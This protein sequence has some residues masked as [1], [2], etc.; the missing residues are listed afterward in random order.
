[1]NATQG[2]EVSVNGDPRTIATGTTV[3]E[4]VTTLTSAAKGVAVA[5][6]EAVVPR[7][8]WADT[9]LDAGNR[10]EVLTAVQGG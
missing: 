6:D 10:V 4:L 3:A 8:V 2:I 9:V 5:V 7:G 1:M